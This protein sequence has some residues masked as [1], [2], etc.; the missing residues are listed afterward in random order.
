[1]EVV[2]GDGPVAPYGSATAWTATGHTPPT[3][4]EQVQQIV[5]QMLSLP[6]ATVAKL[7]QAL[8]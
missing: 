5:Q 6:P 4:S 3:P 7:K 8:E 2:G 1:M